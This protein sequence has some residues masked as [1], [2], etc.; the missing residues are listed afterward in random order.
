M[1]F[2]VV[3]PSFRDPRVLETIASI[4]EQTFD[5]GQ[6]EIVVQDGGSDAELIARIAAAVGEQGRVVQ[7]EDHGIFDGINRGLRNATGDLILTLGSDDRVR[8][9]DLFVKVAK[10]ATEDQA[11]FIFCALSYTDANWNDVRC[12]PAYR[13]R[14]W[15]YV[16]GRQFAHFS[17]FAAPDLYEKLGYFNTENKVNADYEFFHKALVE[18]EKVGIR[19]GYVDDY[20]VQMKMGG[21][22]SRS[23]GKMMRHNMLILRYIVTTDVR[24]LPGFFLKPLHKALEYLRVRVQST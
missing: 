4:K 24:L 7:E 11:N 13:F 2:S 16:I 10:V 15:T 14:Y 23:L 17:L 18:A 8:D 3:I 1:K 21:N 6:I 20:G 5:P 12:W 9:P 19:P 22:S